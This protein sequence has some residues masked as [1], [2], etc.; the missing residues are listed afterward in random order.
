MQTTE[1]CLNNYLPN[2]RVTE[3]LKAIKSKTT[4]TAVHF[5][6][7]QWYNENIGMRR[8]M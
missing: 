1:G 8:G 5:S 4:I 2:H 3:L 6:A 7:V